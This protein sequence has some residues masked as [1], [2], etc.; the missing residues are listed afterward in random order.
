MISSD[1]SRNEI[2]L[3]R[4]SVASPGIVGNGRTKTSNGSNGSDRKKKTI[5]RRILKK[6]TKSVG[7]KPI[8][9][10]VL[11][12]MPLAGFIFVAFSLI[13]APD[14]SMTEDKLQNSEIR[15]T[16][17][18][19]EL[20]SEPIAVP[21]TKIDQ[22][23]EKQEEMRNLRVGDGGVLPPNLKRETDF[24]IPQKKWPVS[25][26]DE[27]ESF[28]TII[29]PA[30]R[31]EEP[32]TL[33]VPKFWMEKPL[34]DFESGDVL[35]RRSVSLKSG[36][37]NSSTGENK[38]ET[39][40]IFVMIASYRDW[41]C[42]HTVE[43][44]FNT[45][46][47]PERVRVGVVDQIDNKVDD[48]CDEPI[49][50][51]K[52]DPDQALCKFASQIDVY[53]M[54]AILAVG[55]VFARHLGYRLYRGEYYAMQVDA[56]VSFVKN[57]D[58][59]IIDQID[60]TGN[61]MAVLSTY[62][63]DVAGSIDEETGKS[64]RHTRPI[65]CNTD[66][67][68]GGQGKHLRHLSQPEAIPH[69]K[70][71]PQLQPYW[72]AGFSFARGHF[73]VN[74]PYDL[75]LPNIFQGEETSIGIRG[76]TYGYDFYAPEKSVVFHMYANGVNAQKRN[77]V[78]KFWE[79]QNLY[80]GLGVAAMNRLNGI[81]HMNP[82]NVE[83]SSWNHEEESRYG[84]GKARKP[85]KFFDTFGIHVKQQT[86]EQRLCQF[87]DSGRMHRQ[88]TQHLRPDGMGINYDEVNYKF[89]TPK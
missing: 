77:K 2:A 48:S 16:K 47:F 78:P 25:V 22:P 71:S 51:C 4:R 3:S 28:E 29:H 8:F 66:Y 35:M 65:M 18:V 15:M 33:M 64:L 42:R 52:D 36:S 70:N 43:S 26:R 41:Q 86:T 12:M 39:R 55:P 7:L 59:D 11:I 85:E 72:A 20:I 62:L 74:V 45:A 21:Q 63:T 76:F 30:N 75:Y 89:V 69:I 17:G 73:L 27:Q 56:H 53:E 60:A 81:I 14:S 34:I 40:T 83:V 79:H 5:R 87:V 50:P 31:S 80:R 10:C 32:K 9:T 19:S 44:I 6:K 61:D 88:F 23:I 68:G 57:W 1:S 84:L 67:E 13:F 24:F 46:T 58:V 49:A 54:D 82:S 38:S 37:L